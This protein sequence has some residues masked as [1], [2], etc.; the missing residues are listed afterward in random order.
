MKLLLTGATGYIGQHFLSYALAQGAD[1]LALL[2]RRPD[3]KPPCPF[4][5]PSDWDNVDL[6]AKAMEGRDVAVHCAGLAHNKQ[7]QM[8][9]SNYELAVTLADAAKKAGV[10][11][12]VFISSA[13]VFGGWGTF[14]VTDTPHPETVYGQ[15]KF[16]AEQACAKILAGSGTK[17]SVI[18]PPMVVGKDAPG[19]GE[20]LCR[21]AEKHIPLPISMLKTLRS[22]IHIDHL[23]QALW[24]E[25]EASDGNALVHVS[26]P[27]LPA[28][29]LAALILAQNGQKAL[30]LPI[31]R[32]VFTLANA[33]P[34]LRGKLDPVLQEHVLT[35]GRISLD[36]IV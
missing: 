17:L 20:T 28:R 12:F 1:V 15:A 8:W 18:R 3:D 30:F 16:E 6:L 32:F 33:L 7:G 4:L 9:Q 25:C 36:R 21:L 10:K 35:S 11:R 22:S 23:V 19:R 27:A 29:D 26:D 24:R 14:S 31:P 34:K 5:V 2:R 13:A